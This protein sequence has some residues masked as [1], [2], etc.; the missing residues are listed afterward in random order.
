MECKTNK[1]NTS[2]KILKYFYES[3]IYL[4]NKNRKIQNSLLY[5]ISYAFKSKSSH[6]PEDENQE[7]KKS[8]KKFQ[9]MEVFDNLFYGENQYKKTDLFS[10]L[11][12]YMAKG[13]VFL[14]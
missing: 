12:T 3:L 9:L 2:S 13:K 10:N 1:T 5:W 7:S 6:P 14:F 8:A 4:D 11:P